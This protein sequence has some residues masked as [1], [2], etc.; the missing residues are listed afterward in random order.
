MMPGVGMATRSA[1]QGHALSPFSVGSLLLAEAH[2]AYETKY[3]MG[4]VEEIFLG[5]GA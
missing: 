3:K 5:S 1:S 4:N 2:W